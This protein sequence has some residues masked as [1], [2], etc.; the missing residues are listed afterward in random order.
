LKI[1]R[2]TSRTGSPGGVEQYIKEVNSL[3]ASKSI[4]TFTVELNSSNYTFDYGENSKTIRIDQNR[5]KRIYGDIS[6]DDR[7]V[8]ELLEIFTR[9]KPDIVH[10]HRFRVGFSSI[11]RFL[12]SLNVPVIFTAHDAELI[13]PLSTL[14]IPGGKI[15]EGGIKTRCFFTGCRVHLNLPYEIMRYR[16]FMSESYK[17]IDLFLVPSE[18]LREY[19][20]SFG[21]KNTRLLRSFVN[22][23]L[24]IPKDGQEGTFGYIGRIVQEKGLYQL[25]MACSILKSQGVY[26]KLLI[27]G[28][29]D[30]EN[31]IR[32]LI[33]KK[34]LNDNVTL[35][36]PV[37]GESKEHFYSY[38]QFTV[39]PTLMFDNIPLSVA[40][41]MMRNRP[42][43]AS[44][45]GGVSELVTDS[46]N[47]LLVKPYDINGLAYALEY[48]LKHPEKI[49]KMGQ[50][51][52]RKAREI[53]DPKKHL[54]NMISIYEEIM[55]V[56]KSD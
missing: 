44:K 31:Y 40:E 43:V 26:F 8:N 20:V 52:N 7:I 21:L 39:V 48:V 5:L 46:V 35:L 38:I 1:L 2:I 23:P 22:P 32:N 3:L 17:Y 19:F 6:Q 53:L 45:I 24:T 15:C 14:V 4:D 56:K 29:G 25:I 51:G 13:C 54:S 49:I 34:G 11:T 27:A 33:E 50:E 41:G 42:V 28:N 37:H 12:R 30:Y 16:R 9:E 47:G 10:L 36:G 18:A 55:S